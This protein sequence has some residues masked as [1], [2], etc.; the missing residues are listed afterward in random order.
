MA[1]FIIKKD[2][3]KE[4]FNAQKIKSAVV[5]AARQAGLTA[6]EGAKIAEEVAN[7]I[8]Q[9]VKNLNEI[10]GAEVRARALSQ[11]DAIAP[12]VA[13]AWKKYDEENNK[14]E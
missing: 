12:A 11:L 3:A 14:D 8:A 5:A 13:G 1:N 4:P 6:E 10:L 7:T 9:S 2:G